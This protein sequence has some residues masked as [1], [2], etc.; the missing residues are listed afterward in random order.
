M[1]K[2]H[3]NFYNSHK[4][5]KLINKSPILFSQKNE[6]G[7]TPF[8]LMVKNNITEHLTKLPNC[9]SIPDNKNNTVIT[10]L[11][12]SGKISLALSLL[13]KIPNYPYNLINSTNNT[14]TTLL[15]KNNIFYYSPEI[16]YNIPI[17]NLPLNI[18][19]WKNSQ[20]LIKQLLPYTN[21]NQ[22]DNNFISPLIHC[23]S[24]KSPYKILKLLIKHNASVN[25]H[26]PNGE[27]NLLLLGI[28][29]PKITTL[30]LNSSINLLL[31]DNYKNTPLHHILLNDINVDTETLFKII[32]YSDLF[33]PNI[34][35][36]TCK[37]L[38][39][40]S[41]TYN[42]SYF[43][44]LL[45]LPNTPSPKIIYPTLTPGLCSHITV[46]NADILH[47]M[48]YTIIFL[49]KYPNLTIPSLSP[50]S[51]PLLPPTHHNK[52]INSIINV[53]YD[54]FKELLSYIILWQDKD[55]YYFN[56]PTNLSLKPRF[57]YIKLTLISK[58]EFT[59]ANL[60]LIDQKKNTIERF[61]PYGGIP[62]INSHDLDEFL[63]KKFKTYTY[64]KP[65]NFYYQTFSMDN[66]KIMKK[67]GDP[68]GYC[69]AWTFYYLE[70]RLL[71]PEIPITDLINISTN[72]II[73]S[74]NKP[75]KFIDYIRD[76]AKHLD[77]LKTKYMLDSGISM[78]NVYK[79]VGVS[80]D[81]DKIMSALKKDMSKKL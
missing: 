62:F 77:G 37:E 74:S 70:L 21:P 25:Y 36:Q 46:F 9:L 65:I 34:K 12:I 64:I 47:S 54:F 8:H 68:T 73:K 19:I 18:A 78:D 22:L 59:H 56:T 43:T 7:Y 28:Q 4:I 76:Y 51:S 42:K 61:D 26:G 20:P 33:A 79:I 80:E 30:L 39:E 14:L 31:T 38:L 13:P 75:T 1:N 40:N 69:L 10:L 41:K 6:D 35:G 60:L 52:I 81:I 57:I 44:T 23:F 50:P 29:N 2:A 16:D 55:N 17:P 63:E 71:N 66:N 45:T 67:L 24:L 5:S 49:N 27:Y 72:D 48:I 3:L 53:Y 58:K 32:Y 11:I 15:L